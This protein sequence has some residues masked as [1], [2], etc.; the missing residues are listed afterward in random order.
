MG[1]DHHDPSVWEK[2]VE[3]MKP[4]V[5]AALKVEGDADGT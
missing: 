3:D 4:V 1:F 2:A 5:N